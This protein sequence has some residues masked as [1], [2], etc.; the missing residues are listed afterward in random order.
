MGNT[1]PI[2][3]LSG[4]IFLSPSDFVRPIIWDIMR[5][6]AATMFWARDKCADYG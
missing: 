6:I 2:C 5:F 1:R 3:G 4:P